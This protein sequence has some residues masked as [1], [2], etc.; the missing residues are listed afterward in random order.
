MPTVRRWTGVAVAVAA[1]TLTALVP[2]ARAAPTGGVLV[3]G[4]SLEELTSPYLAKFLP[5]IPITVNAVGGYNSFQILEL[6]EESYDPSQRVI[7]FDAGT[8]DNPSYPQILAENL[9]KVAATVGSRCMVV[10]TIHGL[11]PGGV[12]DS[13]KNRTVAEF[14]AS[15]PGTQTPDWNGFVALHPELM[16]ADHLHPIEAGAEARARL[17]AQGVMACLAESTGR[18]RVRRAVA[19]AGT[20]AGANPHSPVA[21]DGAARSR[22]LPCDRNRAAA[23]D[24]RQHPRRPALT[25]HEV[26]TNLLQSARHAQKLFVYSAIIMEAMREA[27]TDERMDDLVARVD[28]GFVQADA[29]MERFENRVEA[30]F[31]RI[32][33]GFEKMEARFER[34]DARFEK[35]DER[36]EKMDER[37]LRLDE[38]FEWQWRLLLATF[39]TTLVG[40]L[41]AHS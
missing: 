28:R 13:G 14:A 12:D 9:A 39:L 40:F 6:L 18:R 10:P 16:Q 29:R 1:L 19:G 20:G 22:A 27:W 35:V 36:F 23:A 5:G 30:G 24:R 3:V 41:A 32:D 21:R 17:I 2:V 26:G 15:R 31:D 8:N 4:D 34:V 11:H 37:F 33:A 38:R 25:E 7:V